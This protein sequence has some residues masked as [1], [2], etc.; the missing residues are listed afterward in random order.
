MIFP[1]PRMRATI[2]DK[3]GFVLFRYSKRCVRGE[4][5]VKSDL[6]STFDVRHE[7]RERQRERASPYERPLLTGRVPL[8]GTICSTRRSEKKRRTAWRMRPKGGEGRKRETLNA[9][10]GVKRFFLG[11]RRSRS[12]HWNATT[13]C[14]HYSISGSRKDER[15]RAKVILCR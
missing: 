8:P 2:G 6:A 11:T 10:H 3:T 9:R 4:R 15:S 13:S 14:F 12:M 7:Q 1:F 5:N